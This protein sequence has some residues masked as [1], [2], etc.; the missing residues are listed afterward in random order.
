MGKVP[1]FCSVLMLVHLPAGLWGQRS[2]W[3][4]GRKMWMNGGEAPVLGCESC[5]WSVFAPSG[6]LEG[7]AELQPKIISPALY[8]LNASQ[9]HVSWAGGFREMFFTFGTVRG[10]KRLRN[11]WNLDFFFF[12][13][14]QKWERFGSMRFQV[15]VLIHIYGTNVFLT[16]FSSHTA[17]QQLPGPSCWC[18]TKILVN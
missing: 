15:H 14:S 12:F 17:E 4:D 16:N 3:A 13:F 2:A 18:H 6:Q 11:E 5:K 7:T 1:V 8:S 9:A 10:W